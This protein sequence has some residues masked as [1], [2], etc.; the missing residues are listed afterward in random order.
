MTGLCGRINLA[1]KKKKHVIKII[2]YIYMLF[3]A[4]L[5]LIPKKINLVTHIYDQLGI[6]IFR[7][8]ESPERL[9]C[10]DVFARNDI[11]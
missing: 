4:K 11:Y 3:V 9:S 8:Q 10:P 5:L 1:K 2:F 7:P 6:D